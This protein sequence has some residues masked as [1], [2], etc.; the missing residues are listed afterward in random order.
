[1]A[2]SMSAVQ[3]MT[4]ASSKPSLG[5]RFAQNVLS[6]TGNTFEGTVQ[7]VPCA[8]QVKVVTANLQMHWVNAT[9]RPS[10]VLSVEAFEALF[11][12][13]VGDHSSMDIFFEFNIGFFVVDLDYFAGRL[14]AHGYAYLPLRWHSA[15]DNATYYSI[16]ANVPG[17]TTV[18]EFIG[19]PG[20]PGES[21]TARLVDPALRGLLRR[22]G[23]RRQ[24]M[25][26]TEIYGSAGGD[27]SRYVLT[28]EGESFLQ[29]HWVMYPPGSEAG[30]GA[31]TTLKAAHEAVQEWEDYLSLLTA[32]TVVSPNCGFNQYLDF[33]PGIYP[34]AEGAAEGVGTLDDIL[35]QF[36]RDKV[37]FRIFH[38]WDK[39]RCATRRTRRSHLRTMPLTGRAFQLIGTAS[40]PWFRRNTK[41]WT[42][43]SE[44]CTSE[45]NHAVPTDADSG[46][47]PE[48]PSTSTAGDVTDGIEAAS[49]NASATA[50]AYVAPPS[51]TSTP[52]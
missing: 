9:A 16:L 45:S 46:H 8:E 34:N 39:Q 47:L 25:T 28:L 43:C 6:A 33:H 38:A 15:W 4:W 1:M 40:N 22:P 21:R 3:K 20:G 17:T 2:V 49:P 12:D 31:S 10:G 44:S 11:A 26:A 7:S 13:R 5:L 41:P 19:A 29:W 36:A 37:N 42:L 50:G 51:N 14:E 48:P 23:R 27:E 52:I 18:V 30:N 32:H 24:Y 35:Y